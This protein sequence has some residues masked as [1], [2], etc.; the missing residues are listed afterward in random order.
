MV[1]ERDADPQGLFP[2]VFHFDSTTVG[3][4]MVTPTKVRESTSTATLLNT[5]ITFY[6]GSLTLTL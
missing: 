2:D 5:R 3:P 6:K 4:E 1:T